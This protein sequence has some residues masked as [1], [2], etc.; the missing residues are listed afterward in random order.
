[1]DRLEQILHRENGEA[2]TFK[3]FRKWAVI[4]EQRGDLFRRL[5]HSLSR[6]AGVNAPVHGGHPGHMVLGGLPGAFHPLI[7]AAVPNGGLDSR[8]RLRNGCYL[9]G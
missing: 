8:G 2:G 4:M 7:H 5:L 1:M 9:L 3:N 6:A